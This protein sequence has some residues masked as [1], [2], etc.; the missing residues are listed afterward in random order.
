[1]KKHFNKNVV[2]SEKDEQIFQSSNNCWICNKLFDVGDNKVRDYSHITGIYGGSVHWNCN[3]NLR[4]DK[5]FPVIFHNL[6]SYGSHFIIRE[7]KK[8]DVKVNVIQ[9]GLENYMAFTINNN[10]F[11]RQH[12]I[13]KV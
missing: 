4:L 2:M 9:N 5:R 11:H 13:Y 1:M 10:S 8:L 6:R 3:I 7:I 12:V